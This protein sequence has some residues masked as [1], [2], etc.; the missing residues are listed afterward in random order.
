[1]GLHE[2][3]IAESVVGEVDQQ[4]REQRRVG[5]WPDA[6]EQVGFLRGLGPARIDDDELG[7]AALLGV[8]HAAEQDRVAP[9]GVGAD[10]HDQVGLIEILVAARH[11]VGAKRPAVGRHGARHAQ[12]RIGVDVGR[13][14]EALRELVG[15]VVILGEE[16]PGEVEGNRFRAVFLGDRAELSHDRVEGRIPRDLRAVDLR[17]KQAVVQRQGLAKRRAL[18]AQ[19][20]VIGRMLGIARDGGAALPVRGREH[21]A[22]DPAI[23]ASGPHRRRRRRLGHGFRPRRVVLGTSKLRAGVPRPL[24]GGGVRG[25]G[26]A[27]G[28][29]RVPS[30]ATPTS[31]SSPQGGGESGVLNTRPPDTGRPS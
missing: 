22:P 20:A 26:G 7:A 30:C 8:G 13:A 15:D 27:E 14:D 23:G 19:A 24:A 11:R 17:V 21:A 12:P 3:A 29:A 6:E 5:P 2:G 16:L 18:R 4:A 28:T 1:M 9:R 31:S 10:Q 25:G